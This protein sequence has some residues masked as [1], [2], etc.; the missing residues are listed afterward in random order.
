MQMDNLRSLLGIT[1]M[2]TVPNVWISV[3]YEVAKM[4]DKRINESVLQ[5]LGPIERMGNDRIAKRV[6]VGV[7]EDSHFVG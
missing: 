1:R 3:L 5:W 6:Y 4:V 7:C 2:D